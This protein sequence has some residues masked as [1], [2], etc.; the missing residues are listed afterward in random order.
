MKYFFDY[1]KDNDLALSSEKYDLA[2]EVLIE[3][4]KYEKLIDVF[5]NNNL[6][7]DECLIKV[8]VDDVYTA[9]LD[10]LCSI[11]NMSTTYLFQRVNYERNAMSTF[12][13]PDKK[14][15][16][17]FMVN[18]QVRCGKFVRDNQLRVGK[19]KVF[20]NLNNIKSI[21]LSMNKG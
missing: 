19:E 13:E 12:N 1:K 5:K 16:S 8:S 3:N 11:I 10:E 4:A 17:R 9:S 20:Q 2:D 14:C 18:L 15:H 6:T 7:T 21:V